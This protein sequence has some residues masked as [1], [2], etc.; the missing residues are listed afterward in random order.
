MK[1][2]LICPEGY[3]LACVK[4]AESAKCCLCCVSIVTPIGQ[5]PVIVSGV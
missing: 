2:N 5:S 1:R 3:R 4:D